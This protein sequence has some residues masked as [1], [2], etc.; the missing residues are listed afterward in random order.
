[1]KRVLFM[2]LG[3]ICRSPTAEGV[4]RAMISEADRIETDS[5]GTGAYHTGNPPDPRAVAEAA[6]RGID[7]SDLR[8][9]QV[10]V[11]DFDCF[12]LIVAMDRANLR[13]LRAMAP[14]GCRGEIRMMVDGAEVPD[15]YYSGGFGAVFD[16]L[17]QASASLLQEMRRM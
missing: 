16:M 14:R 13:A 17:E 9:R 3:N 12:D 4:F 11:A 8:A 6:A 1:M 15:P 2:C 10:E 5:A 7:I